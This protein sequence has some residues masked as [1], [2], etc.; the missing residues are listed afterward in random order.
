MN[1]FKKKHL[2]F[3]FMFIHSCLY[4]IESFLNT[5]SYRLYN[6][7]VGNRLESLNTNRQM[8]R[9]EFLDSILYTQV[10]FYSGIETSAKMLYENRWE[11]TFKLYNSKQWD[12]AQAFTKH[13]N[14][15]ERVRNDSRPS[16]EY[17]E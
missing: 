16:S 6:R 11:P 3:C 15:T 12:F 14:E 4:K 1:N 10:P 7:H 5:L 13:L 9:K 17:I 8:R 2:L